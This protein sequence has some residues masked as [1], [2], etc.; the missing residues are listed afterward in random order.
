MPSNMIGEGRSFNKEVFEEKAKQLIY[1]IVSNVS[2]PEIK[3]KF[4]KGVVLIVDY[5]TGVI[6]SKDF[7]KF[8]N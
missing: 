1:I 3:I 2:F 5:P 4:V 8:F 7:V 6:P